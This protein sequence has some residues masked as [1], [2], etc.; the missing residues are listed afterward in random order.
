M[1]DKNITNGREDLK[2]AILQFGNS[3][4]FAEALGVS[5]CTVSAWSHKRLVTPVMAME[6]ERITGGHVTRQ[7]LRPDLNW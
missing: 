6:I 2:R 7:Q 5:L 3:S 4:R 1:E